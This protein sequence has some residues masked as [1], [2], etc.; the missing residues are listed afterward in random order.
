[1]TIGI[2]ASRANREN[3]TG[4]EW[5]SYHLIQELKKMT[6][7]DVI[8]ASST[9]IPANAGIQKNYNWIH[10]SSLPAGRQ[11]RDDKKNSRNDK[12]LLYTNNSLEGD[13]AQLPQMPP[14]P[15]GG[16]LPL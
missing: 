12:F 11:V 6:S 3:K 16:Q 15:E 9:V 14:L 7:S 13:L 8:T 2:D 10:G 5:Y 4:V 1:M